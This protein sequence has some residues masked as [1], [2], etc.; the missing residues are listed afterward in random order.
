M[1]PPTSHHVISCSFPLTLSHHFHLPVVTHRCTKRATTYVLVLY[2]LY[3][4]PLLSLFALYV[5]VVR[6]F[7]FYY[8]SRLYLDSNS[9][10]KEN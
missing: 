9:E 5:L 7:L 10:E 8:N 6:V 2:L 1:A 4:L 3:I